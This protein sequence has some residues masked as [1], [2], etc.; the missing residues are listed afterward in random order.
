LWSRA[1]VRARPEKIPEETKKC[2]MINRTLVINYL[3][4]LVLILSLNFVLPRLMP[5]DPRG[6][7]AASPVYHTGAVNE[8]RI[9]AWGRG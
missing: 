7:Y 1:I 9:G 6:K 3:T 8:S 4:A 2:K 5:G